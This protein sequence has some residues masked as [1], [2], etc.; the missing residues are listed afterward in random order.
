MNLQEIKICNNVALFRKKNGYT[1]MEL[2]KLTSLSQ[3]Y[4]SRV[5]NGVI[6]PS[7]SKAIILAEALGKCH[8]EV[9]YKCEK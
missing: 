3:Q 9:F 7:I 8:C 2:S 4:I 5:E 1:Q 6:V